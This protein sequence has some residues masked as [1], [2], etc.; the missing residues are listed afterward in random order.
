MIRTTLVAF[1]AVMAAYSLPA[2]GAI[3]VGNSGAYHASADFSISGNQLTVILTNTATTDIDVASQLL[4]A[5]FFDMP[6]ATLTKQ[7]A[8]LTAGSVVHKAG[9]IYA[10]PPSLDVGSV[11][12]YKGSFSVATSNGTATKGISATGFGVFGP[13]DI[14]P[15]SGSALT[16]DTGTPPD[17]AAWGITSSGDVFSTSKG[18]LNDRP[19]IKNSVVFTLL[20]SG[21]GFTE[22]NI[23]NVSFQYGTDLC[24]KNVPG[25]NI[26]EPATFLVWS[27]LGAFAAI[28]VWR[29]R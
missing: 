22:S 27:V 24:E 17:G 12:A 15:Y 16:G 3:F 26:P 19:L 11:W 9:T 14:F 1:L 23:R 6:G 25:L 21:T 28:Y 2:S 5:L 18:S 29:R 10:T 8:F 7:S 4:T 20:G 13:P